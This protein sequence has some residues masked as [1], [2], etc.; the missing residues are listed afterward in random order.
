MSFHNSS[1]RSNTGITMAL[2]CLRFDINS[3]VHNPRGLFIED[4]DLI[5][6][7]TAD[8]IQTIQLMG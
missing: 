5:I 6:I 4:E 7:Y 8:R 2:Q 3:I 1:G